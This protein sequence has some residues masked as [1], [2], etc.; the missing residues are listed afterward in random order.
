M[1]SALPPFARRD[2]ERQHIS[3][4]DLPPAPPPEGAEWICRLP[5]L[6]RL[7]RTRYEPDPAVDSW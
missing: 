5:A 4:S 7:T 3:L 2:G 6:G 1:A